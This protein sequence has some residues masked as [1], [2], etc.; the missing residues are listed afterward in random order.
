MKKTDH[1]LSQTME[2]YLETIFVLSKNKGYAR[3]G[4]IARSL[5]VSPSS[6]VEMVGKIAKLGYAEW[7]RYEGVFLSPKGRMHGE[8]IHIRHET[9]RQF[10]EFIGVNQEIANKEACI[11]EHELSPVTTSAIGNFVSFLNTP[12]GSQSISALKLFLKL[13]STGLTWEYPVTVSDPE[14][15]E[16]VVHTAMK[17]QSNQD[18]LSIITRHDLL[19]T[20]TALFRYLDLLKSMTT[21][22]EMNLVVSRIEATISAIN[23]QISN[24][25]DH[26]IPGLSGHRWIN[27]G[28]LVPGEVFTGDTGFVAAK[29]NPEPVQ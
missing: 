29:N 27:P 28:Q 8:V 20:I 4:E 3:T 11:I 24:S 12:A 17:S 7:K 5:N 21:G 6:V 25:S 26:L 14:M 19:N 16:I 13:Q 15:N 9:L 1:K 22:K 18:I 10:F 2:D 23:R